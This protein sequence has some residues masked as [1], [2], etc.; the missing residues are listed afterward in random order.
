M[1]LRCDFWRL[2]P[3]R[4]GDERRQC[5]ICGITVHDATFAAAHKVCSVREADALKAYLSK[6]KVGKSTYTVE[7]KKKETGT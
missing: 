3:A 2:N 5:S 4:R 7:L 1:D 6:N